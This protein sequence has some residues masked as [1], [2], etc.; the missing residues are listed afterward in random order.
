MNGNF[1]RHTG[2]HQKAVSRL[3]ELATK[4][5][6]FSEAMYV[7]ML[8]LPSEYPPFGCYSGSVHLLRWPVN[9]SNHGGGRASSELRSGRPRRLSRLVI[10][11]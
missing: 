11:E 2:L 1:G 5:Q 6:L 10:F 3:R 8:A 7:A 4:E 9:E